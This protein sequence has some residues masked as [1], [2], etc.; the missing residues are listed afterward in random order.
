MT[1]PVILLYRQFMMSKKQ[2][3]NADSVEPVSAAETARA[4]ATRDAIAKK[5]GHATSGFMRQSS[6]DCQGHSATITKAVSE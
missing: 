3:N 2:V 4:I 6:P 5:F 1:I